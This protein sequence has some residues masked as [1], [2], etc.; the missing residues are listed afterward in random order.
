MLDYTS[1]ARFLKF[2]ARGRKRDLRSLACIKADEK[3][4]DDI[5]VVRYFPE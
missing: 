5:R 3:K 1:S 4:L 2:N